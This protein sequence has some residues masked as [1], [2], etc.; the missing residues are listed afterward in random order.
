MKVRNMES[1]KGKKVP[2]QMIITTDT[3]VY[4][5]SY[6][7]VIA[8]RCLNTGQIYL[9]KSKWD[10]SKTTGIYR[11]QFLGEGVGETRKKIASGEYLLADLNAEEIK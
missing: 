4:F 2:N 5:Q 1:S 11:N 6:D 3:D 9:D 8:R 10:Y 7:T